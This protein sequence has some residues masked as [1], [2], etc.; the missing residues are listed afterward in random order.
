MLPTDLTSR[1]QET[2]A[3]PRVVLASDF[4]GTL[5][6][7]VEDPDTSRPLDGAMDVLREATSMAGVTA[8]LVSGRDVDTLRRLS[9]ADESIVLI[10]SHGGQTSRAEL[11]TGALL[12]DEA[13]TRLEALDAA[14]VALQRRHPDARIER[15]PAAVALHTRGLAEEKAAAA[16]GDATAL[17]RSAGAHVLAGKSVVE[18]AVIE[19][20]KGAG[21]RAL[22]AAEEA[23][24][25]VYLGDDVTDE[26]AFTALP[27]DDGHVTVKVGDGDTAA[28]FRVAEI[29]D[30]L[31]VLECFVHAR[32]GLSA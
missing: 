20:N 27:A 22:A 3:L 2:A 8:A 18:L 26:F 5:A 13:R 9:G 31:A 19:T 14:L 28:A 12:D 17:G 11:S 4:D 32:R 7:F 15:K 30:V 1:L 6:P 24:A 25:V 29:P 21:L 10:G 23:D 16:L